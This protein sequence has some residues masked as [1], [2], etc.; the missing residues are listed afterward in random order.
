MQSLRRLT[1]ISMIKPFAEQSE[2]DTLTEI[3]AENP[4]VRRMLP[5]AMDAIGYAAVE[6]LWRTRPRKYKKLTEKSMKLTMEAVEK[7]YWFWPMA[8]TAI[9]CVKPKH[10]RLAPEGFLHSTTQ[11]AVEFW[12]NTKFSVMEGVL[13]PDDMLRQ[14]E[15]IDIDKIMKIGNAEVTRILIEVVGVRKIVAHYRGRRL[16]EEGNYILWELIINNR[17]CPHLEMVCN[18]TGRRYLEGVTPNCKTVNDALIFRNGT[19]ERPKVLT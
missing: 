9:V 6:L 15:N 16:D 3:M 10:L 4:F 14:P 8:S 18:S 7:F 5:C 17:S 2:R 11:Y 12:D 13:V 19:S 1:H